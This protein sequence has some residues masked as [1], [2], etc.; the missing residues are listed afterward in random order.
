M[1]F[2]TVVRLKLSSIIPVI[3]KTGYFPIP[4]ELQ[5]NIKQFILPHL[6]HRLKRA[7]LFEKITQ[8]M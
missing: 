6:S 2:N 4:L 5:P 1:S 3:L 7:V 8:Y